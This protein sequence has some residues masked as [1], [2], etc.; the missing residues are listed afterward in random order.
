[1]ICKCGRYISGD[2]CTLCDTVLFEK[3]SK[4][5]AKIIKLPRAKGK[6]KTVGQLDKI[7]WGI[8]SEYIRRRD[9]LK[10]S[11]GDIAKCITCS[12]I[13]HWKE[14]DCGHGIS[15]RHQGT[16]YDEKNNHFQCKGCNGLKAGKQFEYMLAVDRMYGKGTAEF[17]L[18]KSKQICKRKAID[19][20]IMIEEYKIKLKNL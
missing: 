9:A 4:V 19:F 2:Y 20:K 17:L 11:K 6:E 10:F 1:M 8:F 13:S 5:K 18:M 7:L 12:H 14:G 15:R 16:K 3:Q